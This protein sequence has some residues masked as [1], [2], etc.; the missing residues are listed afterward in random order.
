MTERPILFSAPM[1]RAIL[2]GRKTQTRRVAPIRELNVLQHPGDMITWSVRFT[3]AVKG[4]LAIHSGGKFSDLQARS[5]I[6]S[7]FNPYGK[8]GD[9][10]WVRE[11]WGAV[12]PADEPVPLRQCEIEYR[13][14]LPPDCTDRPGEWPADECNDPEAP[15]W[16][17]SIH[18]PRWASRITLRITDIRVERLQD[19]SE[20]DAQAEG[21][22]MRP[23]CNGFQHRYP[24]WSMDWS[25]VGRLSHYA[26]G[27]KRGVKA[28]LT[29]G[30]VSLHSPKWAFASLWNEING[31]SA[32]D[33]N[34]W[35]WAMTFERVK[36]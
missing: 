5:I 29:E 2:Q 26:T 33:E 32:W 12:W 20:A 31:P 35:V 28:P 18:M 4:T 19:I 10:L 13:A 8:P 6:A 3:K 9:L 1:V 14:D 24:G 16:R 17:P 23:A 30:D 27:A 36:P 11:T 15:K 7:Q 34:P 21:A 25:K 22:T